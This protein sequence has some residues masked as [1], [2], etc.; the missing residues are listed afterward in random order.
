MFGWK[1]LQNYY[2]V[3]EKKEQFEIHCRNQDYCCRL[4]NDLET[5]IYVGVLKPLYCFCW[6]SETTCRTTMEEAEELK[7]PLTIKLLY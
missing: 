4:K 6:A 1:N 7:M 2:C 5:G 3:E